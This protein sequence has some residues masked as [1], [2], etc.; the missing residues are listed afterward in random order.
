MSKLNYL[1]LLIDKYKKLTKNQ[2]IGVIHRFNRGL[3][4]FKEL[5]AGYFK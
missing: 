1:T 4:G 3:R 2:R 5:T